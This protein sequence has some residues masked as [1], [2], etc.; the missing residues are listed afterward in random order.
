M[1]TNRCPDCDVDLEDRD[2]DV[3][4]FRCG[5]TVREVDEPRLFNDIREAIQQAAR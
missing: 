4:C 3:R 1:P 2:T 5:Y